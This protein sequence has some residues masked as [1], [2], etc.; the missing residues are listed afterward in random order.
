M[1]EAAIEVQIASGGMARPPVPVARIAL[2]H[3]GA[4]NQLVVERLARGAEEVPLADVVDTLV[5][6]LESALLRSA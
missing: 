5:Y 1:T 6:T 4:V 3:A 2:A